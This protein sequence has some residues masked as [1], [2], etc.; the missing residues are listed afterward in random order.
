MYAHPGRKL[1]F[2]GGEFGQWA[3]WNHNRS[4]DWHL[5]DGPFHRGLQRLVQHLNWLYTNEPAL[6]QLEDSHEG[7]EWI[8]FHDADASVVSFL[9]KSKGGDCLIVLVNA[10]PVPRLDY[11]VGVPTQGFYREILNSDAGVYGGSNTGNAGGVWS[12]PQGWQGRPYS[13]TLQLPPLSVLILKS[14]S[15]PSSQPEIAVSRENTKRRGT[16]SN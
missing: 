1:L 14:E 13:L 4:L 5:L 2:M 11:R 3:E 15:H 10:T 9:R 6:H 12:H 8:D 7:F 16:S